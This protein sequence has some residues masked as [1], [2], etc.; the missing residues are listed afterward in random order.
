MNKTIGCIAS[1]PEREHLLEKV[2][3]SVVYQVD[4]LY[5]YL[6]GYKSV[7]SFLNRYWVTPILSDNSHWASAKMLQVDWHKWYYFCFDDDLEYPK[8]YVTVMKYWIDIYRWSGVVSCHGSV[9]DGDEA[10]VSWFWDD[11]FNPVRVDLC[12]TGVCAFHTDWVKPTMDIFAEK[13]KVD[14]QLGVYCKQEWI[15]MYVIP[16]RW[17]RLT[18]LD[19]KEET[20][21]LWSKTNW[22]EILSRWNSHV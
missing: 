21:S 17:D 22:Q 12:W 10:R 18:I 1:I 2:I 9:F 13:N 15:P 20:P 14:L 7:P 19:P 8:D 5:V 4:H 16:H 11:E 3:D 6:N